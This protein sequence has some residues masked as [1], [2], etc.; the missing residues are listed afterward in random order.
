[1]AKS[2]N[3]G[4]RIADLLNKLD[5]S[6]IIEVLSDD[7][8][9]HHCHSVLHSRLLNFLNGKS[10]QISTPNMKNSWEALLATQTPES[11]SNVT[12]KSHSS[13]S[14]SSIQNSMDRCFSQLSMNGEHYGVSALVNNRQMPLQEEQIRLSRVGR[15]KNFVHMERVNGKETNV[16][17]GLELHTGVF[18][19]EEQK[20]IVD[21]VYELQ[22]MGQKGQLKE[23]TYS[24]PKKWMRGKGRVT[25]Q[26]GCCYNY[27]DDK[28]GNPPGIVRA[29]EVDPLPSLFKQI[30]KRLVRWH[31]LPPTCIPDSCIVNIYDQGD[32]IPPHIDHHDFLRPFCTISFLTECN[33]LFGTSL[34]IVGPG[35]FSGPVSIPLPVGSVLILNGNGADVA[36]HCVP[37]VPSKRI[38]ITFRKMDQTKVP[39]NFLP[40][41]E[42]LSVKPLQYSINTIKSSPASQQSL[43]QPNHK[44]LSSTRNGKGDEINGNGSN[45]PGATI[46]QEDFPTLAAASSANRQRGRRR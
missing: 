18:D 36:R 21:C 29:E 45:A 23:R 6:E 8:F 14:M 13:E 25:M 26:F 20:K 28:N 39:L 10:S 11:F 24:E 31:V 12:Q 3:G 41:P 16:L 40:D 17:R 37:G 7:G 32:C 5:H 46:N 33:I 42:L 38:S 2:G 35:D 19:A 1:M 30:I 22:R 9:C 15:K 27:S 4:E 44:N 43:H 34:K